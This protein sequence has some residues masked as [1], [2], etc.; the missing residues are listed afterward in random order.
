MGFN[1]RLIFKT[2]STILLFEGIAMIIPFIFACYYREYSPAT[3]FFCMIVI[4]VTF[5]ET[6][7]RV[8]PKG[9][10]KLKSREGYYV[11]LV[12]WFFVIL[13]GSMPYYL[14]DQGYS[15]VDC[16][17][18]SCAGW[19]TTGS[20]VLDPDAMPRSLFAWK[21]ITGWLGGMGIIVLTISVFPRL[22]IGGQKMAAAEVPGPEL[23][24]L[25]ARFGDTAKI[26]YRTY[27]VLTVM[28]F[29]LLL[30]S[31]MGPYYSFINTLSTISTSGIVTIT[32][33]QEAFVLTTYVKVVLSV[34]S[35]AGAIS[36]MIYF[37]IN[38]KKFDLVFKHYEVR[39]YVL[40]I[41]ISASLI[42][43]SLAM[44][45]TYSSIE[46]S[47]GMAS[48]ETIAYATTTGFVATD[49]G[50]WPTFAKVMLII[51]LFI[52]G[53]GFS[54]SGGIKVIRAVVFFKL[55]LRGLYKRIHPRSIKPIMTAGKP[56]SATNASSM[57]VFLL[58]YFAVF[59]LSSILLGLENLDM[60]TTL[61]AVLAT[62]ST[63]GTGV[64]LLTNSDFSIFSP[65]GKIFL[66]VLM[67]IGRLEL[68]AVII[69]FSRSYW[70]M[71]RTSS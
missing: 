67:L 55:I 16:W 51:L 69:M 63:G 14:S 46:E 57:T 30:C 64:G 40:I 61:S 24:K 29:V 6:M 15:L 44:S 23:D 65:L 31:G 49:I 33:A 21:A 5:G 41:I 35:M 54:T 37:Y 32:S 47:I 9:S 50:V 70:N 34:F 58:L 26:C 60:E 27:V 42:A 53:C 25:T 39:I 1:H 62:M 8:I 48:L 12:S 28:E 20:F 19:T 52:G 56:I 18:E 22:G 4:C 45:G 59:L 7:R 3:S 36:F 66:T 17:F 38:I 2:V 11:V 71:D 13:L 43:T 10:R 68:Y